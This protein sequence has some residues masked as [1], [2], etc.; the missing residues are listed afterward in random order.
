MNLHPRTGLAAGALAVGLL[1]APAAANAAV[2]VNLRIEGPKRTVFEGRITVPVHQ[3]RFTGQK[4]GHECD[5]VPQGTQSKS[6]PTR[7]A[8]IA[9]AAQRFGFSLKGSWSDQFGSP[10]F[11]RVGGQDVTFDPVTSRYL[12]EFLN[13]KASM[14]GS[15][16]ERVR[17]GDDVLFAYSTGSE[18]LL[19]L[20]GGAQTLAPGKRMTVRVTAGGDPVAGAVVAGVPTGLD[21][22]A[23]VGPFSRGYHD[24]KATKP[25]TVRSNRLRVCV[26][27]RCAPIVRITDIRKGH[28]FGRHAAPRRLRGVV[29]T[30]PFGLKKLRLKLTRR[31]SGQTLHATFRVKPRR[32]W[33]LRLPAR[34]GRGRYVLVAIATD[35]KGHR[36]HSRVAFSVR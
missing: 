23:T 36:G 35:R 13:G 9:L 31:V 25:G 27:G 5:G 20:G 22:R 12:A 3:F 7:G 34:P 18:P 8:A 1:A 11:D 30:A 14:L 4:A 15:C 28:R 17:R 21:G 26:T 6:V 16:A 24:L 32:D 2:P 10:S 19:A 33:S 29:E